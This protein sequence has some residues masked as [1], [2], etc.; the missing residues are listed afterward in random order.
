MQYSARLIWPDGN[1]RWMEGRGNVFFDE[2]GKALK[3]TGT[4]RDITEEKSFSQ[5]LENMVDERTREL[6]QANTELEK[7]NQ[8]LASFAYVSSH[9]LQE[10]LRKIQTFASRVIEHE[11]HNLS[12][13]G[14]DYFGRMQEAARRMQLL[15]QDLLAYSRT[16]RKEKEFVKSDLNIL[17]AG[18]IEDLD[19]II[20]EK[21][22]TI[23]VGA[24]PEVNVIPFQFRQLL[25]NLISNSLK[26]QKKDVPPVID[27]KSDSVNGIEVNLLNPTLPTTGLRFATMELVLRMNTV[28]GFLKYFNA[29]IRGMSL[30]VPALDL[31]SV[32]RLWKIIRDL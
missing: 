9:D 8:E 25:T 6:Q 10:P 4:I 27:I 19:Q 30:R 32:R 1:I 20:Q 12:L 5:A 11:Y 29:C 7:I 17:A 21:K 16:N 2:T 18:V 14:K 24:L 13:S 3:M 31:P 22:A 23:N 26:F 28:S 15:I